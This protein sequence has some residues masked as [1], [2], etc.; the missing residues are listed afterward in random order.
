MTKVNV[1]AETEPLADPSMRTNAL[2]TGNNIYAKFIDGQ[3]G[4]SI[5]AASVHIYPVG[6]KKTSNLIDGM[7]R[8]V[9]GEFNFQTFL[10]LETLPY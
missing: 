6:K 8:K 5:E 10:Q 1:L 4:K 9:N 3:T 2:Q 7:L